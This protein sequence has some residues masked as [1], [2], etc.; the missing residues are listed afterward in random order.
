MAQFHDAPT[1][2]LELMRGALPHYD[3]LQR[4][5]VLATAD[6]DVERILDLGSGTGETSRRCLVAH[7]RAAVVAID[8]SRAMTEI[9]STVPEDRL[10]ALTRRLEDPLPPGPFDLVVSALAVHHLDGPGKADLFRRIRA[11]LVPGGRFV[12]G[13]VIRPQAPVSHPAPLD[14]SVDF[15]D[16][17]PHLMAWLVEADLRPELRWERQDLVVIAASAVPHTRR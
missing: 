1:R 8:Q 13:D 14:P 11:V 2:Y 6:L 15:P 16:P 17:L 9:A 12:M 3:E 4:Q 10:R 5:V 7:P